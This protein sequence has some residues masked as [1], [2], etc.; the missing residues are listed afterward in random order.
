MDHPC[1]NTGLRLATRVG[2]RDEVAADLL[3]AA[4]RDAYPLGSP[5]H[6]LLVLAACAVAKLALPDYH[7]VHP[8]DSRLACGL[9]VAEAWARGA[10]EP[11]AVKRA[12]DTAAGCVHTAYE[13]ALRDY[14]GRG[15]LPHAQHDAAYEAATAISQALYAVTFP[16]CAHAAVPKGREREAAVILRNRSSPLDAASD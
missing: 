10:A 9:T 8:N 6:R 5:A 13:A 2:V 12:A 16:G 11:E 1:P 14:Y 7:R 15:G 3:V 4:A